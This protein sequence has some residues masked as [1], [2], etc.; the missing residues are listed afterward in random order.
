MDSNKNY[1]ERSSVSTVLPLLLVQAGW[2]LMAVVTQV[3]PSWM[4]GL[5]TLNESLGTPDPCNL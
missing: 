5:I 2:Y 3:I 4:V 1:L